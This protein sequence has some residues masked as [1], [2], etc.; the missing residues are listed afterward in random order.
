M[1][2]LDGC[3][4]FK[5]ISAESNE[6]L[7]TFYSKVEYKA[8]EYNFITMYMWQEVYSFRY[9]IKGEVAVIFGEYEGE[10]FSTAPLCSINMLNEGFQFIE[11]LFVKLNRPMNLKAITEDIKDFV[12][13]R[14]SG[15]LDMSFDRDSSDYVYDADKLRNL[16]GRKMHS[17]KNHFNGFVKEYGDRFS[18]R[19]L[20]KG[21]FGRC[22]EIT[23]RWAFSK[24]KDQNLIG[25]RLAIQKV[26]KNYRS[27]PQLVVG[28]IY[29]DNILEAFTFG[30]RL[31][32]NMALV[33][34]EKANPNIR[35]LYTAINKL[36]LENEFPDVEYVNREE[37][38]G[39]E[40]LRD[41]KL[42]YKPVMLVDKYQ[43]T[44]MD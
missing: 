12:V 24:E 10:V 39:I 26:L 25:E 27:F 4:D 9:A 32:K 3:E 35:G 29:V 44:M 37:D 43:F 11:E 21:D 20:D 36:F 15:K 2:H 16:S 19:R 18:Y 33:H 28:G 30:D 7:K 23:E 41:A 6:I 40:G 8:C 38:L 14:Y 22:I 31:N 34:I 1:G 42:S 5:K 13:N 17:K